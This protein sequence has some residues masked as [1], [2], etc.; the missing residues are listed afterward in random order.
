MYFII[1]ALI[2]TYGSLVYSYARGWWK[3]FIYILLGLNS[4]NPT[5]NPNP[6]NKGIY[7]RRRFLFLKQHCCTERAY[8][9]NQLRK[10]R[11]RV[12]RQRQLGRGV[13]KRKHVQHHWGPG[14]TWEDMR[15]V[16]KQ[17]AGLGTAPE[18]DLLRHGPEA[19]RCRRRNPLDS[20]LPTEARPHAGRRRAGEK[21]VH[22]CEASPWQV[23]QGRGSWRRARWVKGSLKA[24]HPHP[25]GQLHE[26]GDTERQKDWAH[27]RLRPGTIQGRWTREILTETLEYNFYVGTNESII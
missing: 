1:R 6:T 27:V 18:Q 24:E 12:Q 14:Q 19:R 8:G 20:E 3:S 15:P 21:H 4:N 17:Q 10:C 7:L 25:R 2:R 16:S 5:N 22:L 23:H 11:R 26:A 9:G 13:A